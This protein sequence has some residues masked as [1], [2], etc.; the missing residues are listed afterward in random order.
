MVRIFIG[1]SWPYA[2]APIHVGGVS[3]SWLPPDIFARYH[4]MKGNEVLMVSGSDMHGTPITVKAEKEGV[5]PDVLA[6]RFHEINSDALKG[7]GIEFELFFYT[8]HE[9]H[10][11]VVHELFL[12][13]HEN[14]YIFEK[15]MLSPYCSE[16]KRFLP[17][18]YVLGE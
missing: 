8:D 3:S 14:G 1:A 7:M 17:D 9:N 4:R 10:K 2:N 6:K 15:T 11:K 16:C 12:R 13:L 18:R 5:E